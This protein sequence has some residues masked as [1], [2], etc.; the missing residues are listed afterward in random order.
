MEGS[1]PDSFPEL[2]YSFSL[3]IVHT[4]KVD[5]P[6][7]HAPYGWL[8]ARKLCIILTAL[9]TGFRFDGGLVHIL[10]LIPHTSLKSF[11]GVSKHNKN[12]ILYPEI[13]KQYSSQRCNSQVTRL[14]QLHSSNSWAPLKGTWTYTLTYIIQVPLF[15]DLNLFSPHVN[16]VLV[17]NK[18]TWDNLFLLE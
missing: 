6:C 8:W 14:V 12:L 10:K 18:V 11:V 2:L 3:W 15:L 4:D 9:Q 17:T 5:P 1:S 7:I 16:T 13:F